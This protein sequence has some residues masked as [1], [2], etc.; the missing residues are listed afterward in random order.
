M[1]SDKK[2]TELPLTNTILWTEWIPFAKPGANGVFTSGT[3]ITEA[4]KT[5][6]TKDELAAK[7]DR[8][9]AGYGIEITET[10][11]IRS[12]HDLGIFMVVDALPESGLPNKLYLVRDPNGKANE[13][14]YV[15]WLFSGGKWE[16]VGK[17]QAKVDLSP[18]M[19][20]ADAEAVYAKKAS[21]PDFNT[22]ASQADQSALENTVET[23]SGKVRELEAA[24]KEATDKL[25]TIPAVPAKDGVCYALHN[26]T[27]T[28]IAGASEIILTTSD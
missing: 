9:T 27:W 25:A 13:N 17:Y 24:L 20:T 23:L 26:G 4:R 6:A 16:Q 15:E 8:L 21:L 11:E 18:Y 14:E 19:K 3:L 12:T 2:I 22:F 10:N 5:M 28:P 1:E 7:Q